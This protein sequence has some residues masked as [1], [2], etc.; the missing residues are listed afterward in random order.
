[1][2]LRRWDYIARNTSLQRC[3]TRHDTL[4]QDAITI[5]EHR[6]TFFFSDKNPLIFPLIRSHSF[7]SHSSGSTPYR[8]KSIARGDSS[9]NASSSVAI[10]PSLYACISTSNSS[11]SYRLSSIVRTAPVSIDLEV[12]LAGIVGH[13]SWSEGFGHECWS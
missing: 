6:S 9:G 10:F 8:R 7:P 2:P 11:C 5:D 13:Y 12:T 1:M 4:F 3:A